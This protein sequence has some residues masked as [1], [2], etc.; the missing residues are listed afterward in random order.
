MISIDGGSS[1]GVRRQYS[2]HLHTGHKAAWF[3][4]ET[5]V[6]RYMDSLD[7]P[8]KWFVA[9]V[10]TIL[11]LFRPKHPLLQKEDLY[12]GRYTS[13]VYITMPKVR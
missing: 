8:K 11:Q 1:P 4:S 6:Y 9:N 2:F 7:A 12:F 3:I 5:T 10:D 13:R